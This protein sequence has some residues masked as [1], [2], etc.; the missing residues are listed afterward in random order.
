[1]MSTLTLALF[2]A[3]ALYLGGWFLGYW[4]GNFS[5]VL[6]LMLIYYSSIMLFLGAELTHAYAQR[7]AA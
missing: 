4:I 3:L 6:L 7:N 1:M 2:G 5:L